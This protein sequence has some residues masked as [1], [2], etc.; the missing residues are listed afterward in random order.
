MGKRPR[1]ADLSATF[2]RVPELLFYGVERR[3]Y[4]ALRACYS[5]WTVS[6]QPVACYHPTEPPHGLF[7]PWIT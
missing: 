3:S 5:L 2:G 1:T 4:V 6:H 7:L